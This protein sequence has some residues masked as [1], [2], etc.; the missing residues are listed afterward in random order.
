[1]YVRVRLAFF[2]IVSPTIA[3]STDLATLDEIFCGNGDVSSRDTRHKGN[4]RW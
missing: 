3:G 4:D 2:S 1:M